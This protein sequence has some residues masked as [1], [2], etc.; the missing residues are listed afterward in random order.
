MGAPSIVII[1]GASTLP[2]LYQPVVDAVTKHGIPIQALRLPSIG[3]KPGTPPTISDDAAFIAQH[4]TSLA[5]AG[6]DVILVTHSYGGAPGTRCVQGLSKYH[7]QN[8]GLDG[9]VVRI[10]YM[11]SLIPE[12]GQPASSVQASLPP[13]SLVP[14]AVDGN[15]WI[16]YSN[17]TRSAQLSFTDFP[18]EEG[19]F[20]AKKLVK[21]SAAS[22]ATPLTYSGYKDVPVS[23]LLCTGDLTIP[24]WIQ[25]KQID[26]MER[27]TGSTVAV[28]RLDSDHVAPLSHPEAVV[29]W[30]LRLAKVN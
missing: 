29:D 9:G 1:P 14:T 8:Q 19:I 16:Y 15:G 7:R 27:E 24:A 6:K 3:F 5:D 23:Y 20:W 30:M 22:F 25:Q 26:M 10:A 12:L 13:E 2:K 18:L 17:L 11:A 28:T 21:H 4:I